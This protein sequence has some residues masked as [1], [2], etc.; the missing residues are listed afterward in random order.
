LDRHRTRA[1]VTASAFMVLGAVLAAIPH[2]LQKGQAIKQFF[3]YSISDSLSRNGFSPLATALPCEGGRPWAEEPPIFHGLG[4]VFL[5]ALDAPPW[6]LPLLSF[7][8][9]GVALFKLLEGAALRREQR[10]LVAILALSA[11][12]LS[13]Y[14]VQFLPDLFATALLTLGMAEWLAKRRWVS[15]ALWALAVTTKVLVIFPIAAFFV[16]EG[17]LEWRRNRRFGALLGRGIFCALLCI[18]FLA[19]LYLLKT[20]GLPNPFRFGSVAE[21]RHSGSW[22]LLASPGY[23]ARFVTWIMIKGAGPVLFVC[24]WL[25]L[26]KLWPRVPESGLALCLISWTVGVL[27]YWLLVRQGNFVHDYY[28]LPF[29]VPFALCGAWALVNLAHTRA[30]RWAIGLGLMG[31][32]WGGVGTVSLQ[33]VPVD[34][35][36]GRPSFCQMEK[37]D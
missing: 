4:A 22:G 13:R 25:K 28:S 21:N 1:L 12:A 29:V 6:L 14:S 20:R 30:H 34:P 26:R 5:G 31:L 3:A 2:S 16:A 33:T 23:W 32:L 36:L 9:L 24:S 10:A 11:P 35:A 7:F 27:P 19:W 17:Y 8:L 37:G 18:P 15:A